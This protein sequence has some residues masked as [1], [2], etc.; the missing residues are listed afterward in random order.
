M[1][2]AFSFD[3]ERLIIPSGERRLSAVYVSAGEDTPA[4][5]ICHGIGE[6][7]EYWG[8]V[9]G[10]LRDMGVSSLVFNYSGFGTSS[11][12]VSAAHCEE[13]AIAAYQR[14]C[15]SRLPIDC[16]A[17][18]FSWERGRLCGGFAHRF[19]WVG[20]VRRIFIVARGGDARWAFRDG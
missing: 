18:V 6:L 4:V 16:S 10:L 13:D 12:T 3:Q 8:K 7:V 1:L 11:G 9:Q 17:W 5:L 2:S 14:A 20:F 15:R 19:G